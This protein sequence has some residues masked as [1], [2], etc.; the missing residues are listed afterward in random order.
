MYDSCNASAKT[1]LQAEL[2]GF[3]GNVL[4]PSFPFE[5]GLSA[6][7][8]SILYND[9]GLFPKVSINLR[10]RKYSDPVS[11]QDFFRSSFAHQDI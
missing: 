11:S 4:P 2:C 9:R 7:R 1:K 10:A 3:V 5:E 8:L 6:C